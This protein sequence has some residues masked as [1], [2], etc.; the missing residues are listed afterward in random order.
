LRLKTLLS[1]ARTALLLNIM[2]VRVMPEPASISVRNAAQAWRTVLAYLQSHSLPQV[3][4]QN[5]TWT[6]KTLYAEGI[7]DYA[8]TGKLFTTGDWI[9]E[10]TQDVAPLSRTVYTLTVF[11]SQSGWYWKG[12][13]NA[14]GSIIEVTAFQFLTEKERGEINAEFVRK[15][16]IPPPRPG[17]YGH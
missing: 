1:L 7:T 4:A 16:Q 13:V 17:G 10:V 12:Y 2:A 5:T 14:G 11:N 8:V 3:P 6:E 15:S 9:I